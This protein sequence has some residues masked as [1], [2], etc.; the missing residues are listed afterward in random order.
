MIYLKTSSEIT[1][2]RKSCQIIGSLLD[3]LE[4]IIRPGVNTLEL[5]E[6]TED[7]IRSRGGKPS[8]KGYQ[9]PGLK[10][11]PGSICAS[12]NSA[13]VHGIP[14][15]DLILK[16]GDIIGIDVGVELDGYHGD[17]ARTYRVGSVTDEADNLL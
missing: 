14:R 4:G 9:I 8:F 5:D 12:V 17:A 2:M 3:S 7:F 15:R 1:K 11:F 10:P 16:E 6:Y 13:I